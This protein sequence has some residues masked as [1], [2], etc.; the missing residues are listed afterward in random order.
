[1]MPTKMNR[2]LPLI[3]LI[4]GI[5]SLASFVLMLLGL[6]SQILML[7]NPG[8]IPLT[9]AVLAVVS[10]I[11]AIVQIKKKME[12]GKTLAIW[13]LVLGGIVLLLTILYFWVLIPILARVF[14]QVQLQLGGIPD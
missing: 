8:W 5:L 1:M 12:S 6:L 11:T 13:G 2:C 3:S 9:L 7:P 10:S 14:E 4:F